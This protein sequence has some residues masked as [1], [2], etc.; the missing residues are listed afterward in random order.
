MTYPTR[1]IPTKPYGISL[2]LRRHRRAC[3]MSY[4]NSQRSTVKTNIR[5]VFIKFNVLNFG[6][7]GGQPLRVHFRV[8]YEL[9][10]ASYY[11]NSKNFISLGLVIY[12]CIV[13]SMCW[14]DESMQ[15]SR[16][17][18]MNECV[19]V[20]E[21]WARKRLTTARVVHQNG[22]ARSTSFVV[23]SYKVYYSVLLSPDDLTDSLI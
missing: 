23:F 13:P 4:V 9:T 19:H 5:N 2:W 6:L 3:G 21:G 1:N 20:I 16:I 14:V 8:P 11:Q 12:H 22:A 10:H 15:L 18:R 7:C 17:R